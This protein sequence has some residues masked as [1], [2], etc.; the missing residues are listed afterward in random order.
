M[1][2]HLVYYPEACELLSNAVIPTIGASA[3]SIYRFHG[4]TEMK[5]YYY[6]VFAG[7][8]L[9]PTPIFNHFTYVGPLETTLDKL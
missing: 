7:V 6:S 8:S 4:V 9:F 3:T 1:Q 2:F 5:G